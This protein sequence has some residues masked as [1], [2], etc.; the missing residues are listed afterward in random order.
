[1]MD[2]K[3]ASFDRLWCRGVG[4]GSL[5]GEYNSNAIVD[6]GEICSEIPM[7]TIDRDDKLL[8]LPCVWLAEKKWWVSIPAVCFSGHVDVL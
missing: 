2:C 7:E 3:G 8:K 4:G 1:M 6:H 5:A